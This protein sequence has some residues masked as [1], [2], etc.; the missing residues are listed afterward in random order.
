MSRCCN[1]TALVVLRFVLSDDVPGSGTVTRN[2]CSRKSELVGYLNPA[3]NQKQRTIAAL[4][5]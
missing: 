2:S 5:Q 1:A 3:A 4:K